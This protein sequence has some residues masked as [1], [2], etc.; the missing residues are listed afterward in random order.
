MVAAGDGI[1]ARQK[2]FPGGFGCDAGAAGGVFA[3]GDD[4]VEPEFLPQFWEQFRNRAPAR[5][6]HNVADEENFHGKILTPKHTKE[7]PKVSVAG[8]CL[9]MGHSETSSGYSV[10]QYGQ[11]FMR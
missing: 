3:V 9:S 5:L 11:R 1:H 7:K 4:E 6:S 10:L 8:G 2:N